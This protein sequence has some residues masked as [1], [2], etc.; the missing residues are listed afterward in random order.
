MLKIEKGKKIREQKLTRTRWGNGKRMVGILKCEGSID[1]SI[2]RFERE[3]GG[4]FFTPLFRGENAVS[5]K[6]EKRKDRNLRRVL[7]G[8]CR[9]CMCPRD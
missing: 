1:R 5:A 2:D 9:V 4:G 7:A 6:I 3:E 8:S